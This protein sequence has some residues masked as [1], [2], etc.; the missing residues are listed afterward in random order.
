MKKQ[1]R[2]VGKKQAA[3]N[4][5]VTKEP[6]IQEP[7]FEEPALEQ[8]EAEEK[9]PRSKKDD[10]FYGDYVEQPPKANQVIRVGDMVIMTKK[11]KVPDEIVGRIWK[12][13]RE[14]KYERGT[15]MVQLEGYKGTYPADGLKVVG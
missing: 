4:Q 5:P 8:L 12:V 1:K 10:E 2:K 14:P 13:I 6:V 3:S 11:Y 15:R 9:K 7:V